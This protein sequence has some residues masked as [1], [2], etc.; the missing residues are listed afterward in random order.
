MA[1]TLLNSVKQFE[2]IVNTP[3]TEGLMQNLVKI[4]RAVPERKTF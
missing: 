1:A 4:G 3:S 2:Q